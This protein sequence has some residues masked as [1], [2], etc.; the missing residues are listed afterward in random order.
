MLEILGDLFIQIAL[1]SAFVGAY[2]SFK[3]EISDFYKK[4][5]RFSLYTHIAFTFLTGFFLYY[6]LFTHQYQFY[7]AWTHTSNELPWYYIFSAIWEGQEGSFLLWAFWHAVILLILTLSRRFNKPVASGIILSVQVL[8]FSMLIGVF[9]NTRIFVP[10][11]IIGIAGFLYFSNFSR[12]TPPQ[13]VLFLVSILSVGIF[14][15]IP[16]NNF[17]TLQSSL[18]LTGIFI[19]LLIYLLQKQKLTLAPGFAW[20]GV[21]TLFLLLGNSSETIWKIGSSPFILLKEVFPD[22]P[23]YQQNPGFVP[24]NGK[25]LNPLLKNY[26]MVIHPP[27]LFLGFALSSVP[28]AFL[29]EG[30]LR[31]DS[32]KWVNL[33]FPWLIVNMLV[34]GI[35]ITLG[36]YWAYETLSF[37]GYWAWD[38]VE[39]ASLVPWLTGIAG[40]HTLLAYK[41]RKINYRY[42]VALIIATFLLILYSTFLTRSGIL[43]DSSVHSFTDLGL[44]GQLLLLLLS[45]LFATVLL[46][47]ERQSV[48]PSTENL[49]FSAQ[50]ASFWL[51]IGAA[52][53]TFAAL[54]ITFATSLPVINKL[55]N[56]HFAQP[57]SIALFY[58]KV[59][60]WIA[61][62]ILLAMAITPFLFWF[63]FSLKETLKKLQIP[64]FLAL[65]LTILIQSLLF[66]YK[67]VFVYDDIFFEQKTYW[68]ALFDDVLIF[69]SL[70]TSLVSLYLMIFL[71]QRGKKQW[72]LLG[73]SF[74]HIGFAL[75]ILGALFSSGF[76]KTLSKTLTPENKEKDNVF[77]PA[78]NSNYIEGFEVTYLG[79]D[80][81]K[82]PIKKV[83]VL[84][85]EQEMYKLVATDSRNEKYAFVL[86]EN[87]LGE[88]TDS[89]KM[90]MEKLRDLLNLNKAVIPL[91][92]LDE[93]Q[94]FRLRFRNLQDTSETFFLTPQAEVSKNMGLIAHPDRKIYWNKDI[95]VH[96]TSIPQD[97]PKKEQHMLR[98][99]VGDTLTL[100]DFI[101]YLKSIKELP[102]ED[103]VTF[104]AQAELYLFFRRQ[105]FAAKPV[106]AIYGNSLGYEDF[107]IDNLE[108]N[109]RF[110]GIDTEAGK[111]VIAISHPDYEKDFIT[112]KVIEKPWINVLWLGT[113]LLFLGFGISV[114]RRFVAKT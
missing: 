112:I 105:A 111:I 100:H 75:V 104:K 88:G 103:S 78:Y 85:K 5:F 29:I 48:F 33:A 86:P 44:S 22:I 30:L 65:A 32:K 15:L 8:L 16:V 61:L 94:L 7:Y 52:L 87:L 101:F 26:W 4:T 25:G 55:L 69:T 27:V 102:K 72:K 59:T 110:L 21:G 96:I 56:T 84:Y 77:L 1:W 40:I 54:E 90:A 12:L 49:R 89:L 68:L 36:G 91:K 76:E 46:Y 43:G 19:V 114:Y 42:S 63:K 38:P 74:A 67:K 98:I 64:F 34:L 50:D 82:Y 45:Y 92:R 79:K 70:F 73:G 41:T 109:V 71:L 18:F 14:A 17:L 93:R 113:F 108:M 39:N 28:F 35:G 58:Y 6:I 57:S 106:L 23:V 20:L 62:L 66:Y 13:K 31:R 3:T 10:F 107:Y 83:N 60:A 37:G 95:Y 53:L 99:G 9:V 81:P 2:T 97:E 24:V 80:K 47:S 51:T 11:L